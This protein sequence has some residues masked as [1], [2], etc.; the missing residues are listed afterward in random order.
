MLLLTESY[1][2]PQK[3]SPYK[4][5]GAVSM[6]VVLKR[7]EMAQTKVF[8]QPTKR[9]TMCCYPES[10]IHP[11]FPYLQN[12]YSKWIV[13]TDNMWQ[14]LRDEYTHHQWL[15]RSRDDSSSC[16]KVVQGAG[17]RLNWSEGSWCIRRNGMGWASLVLKLFVGE[18][19]WVQG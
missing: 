12:S 16:R 9:T 6:G 3:W 13:P 7:R 1:L 2:Q 17:I 14:N 19:A 18:T 4:G 10:E 15:Y 11:L 8:L 5:R